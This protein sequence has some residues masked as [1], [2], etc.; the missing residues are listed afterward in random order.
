MSNNLLTAKQVGQ[1]LGVD[2]TT[3]HWWVKQGRLKALILTRGKK[4]RTIRFEPAEIERFLREAKKN[5]VSRVVNKYLRRLGV[6]RDGKER[7]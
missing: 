7:S 3:V 1:M 4:R 5:N 2:Y 6:I